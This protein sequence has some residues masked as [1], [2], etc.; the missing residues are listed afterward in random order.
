MQILEMYRTI[1]ALAALAI[2]SAAFP[3]IA[4]KLAE[5]DDRAWIAPTSDAVRSPC[6]GTN[7][8]ANHGFIN[9]NG[10]G[11]TREAFQ[12]GF[13]DAFGLSFPVTAA[14]ARNALNLVRSMARV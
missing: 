10:K 4:A 1:L 11:I 14:G 9:R 8:L 2:E 13:L 6:P 12:Q 7:T 5:R 3:G